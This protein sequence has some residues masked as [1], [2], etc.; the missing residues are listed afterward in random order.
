MPIFLIHYDLPQ[1]PDV[2]YPELIPIL[3]RLGAK[4][5]TATAWAVRT[6][7]SLTELRD[8]IVICALPG[9]RF[10]IAELS[11]WRTMGTLARID[12]P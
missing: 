9:D 4:R 7:K 12:E 6:E 1:K 11:Q 5:L 3:T 8:E 10:V 2:E